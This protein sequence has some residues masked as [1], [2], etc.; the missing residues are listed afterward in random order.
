MEA[1]VGINKQYTLVFYLK[2]GE[3]KKLHQINDE[4]F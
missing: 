2:S 4:A 3:T 1:K